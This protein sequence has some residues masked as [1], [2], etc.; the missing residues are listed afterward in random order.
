MFEFEFMQRALSVDNSMLTSILGLFTQFE[1]N[2]NNILITLN[3]N[4]STTY[5]ECKNF[6]PVLS[7]IDHLFTRDILFD[8]VTDNSIVNSLKNIDLKQ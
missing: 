4:S 1:F 6:H 3:D 8:Y 5:D 2:S 7:R